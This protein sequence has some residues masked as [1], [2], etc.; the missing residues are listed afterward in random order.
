MGTVEETLD[1]RPEEGMMRSPQQ[2][3]SKDIDIP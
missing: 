3:D 1:P 2:E